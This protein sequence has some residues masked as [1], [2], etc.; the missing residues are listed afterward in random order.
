M[1]K[2]QYIS[3]SLL[4]ENDDVFDFLTE[5]YGSRQFKK[6]YKFRQK[7]RE[8]IA[9]LNI[10]NHKKIN[11]ISSTDE[12]LIIAQSDNFLAIAK[13]FNYHSHPLSYCESDNAISFLREKGHK[14]FYQ[15]NQ[16]SYDRGLLFRLDYVTSGLILFTNN[17]EILKMIRENYHQYVL[18]KGYLA[19]VKGKFITEIND[20]AFMKVSGKKGRVIQVSNEEIDSSWNKVIT[21]ISPL[22]YSQKDDL[23]LVLVNIFTGHRHQ[24]RAHLN[25][26]GF[27]IYGDDLY[28]DV[29]R[30]RVFLHSFKYKIKNP[31]SKKIETFFCD[32]CDLF[33]QFFNLDVI[34][35]KIN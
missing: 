29:K 35:N 24:I 27:P 5:I 7:S 1:S 16:N 33:Y 32:R 20:T 23:S 13:P 12:D 26:L 9:D 30:E 15:I 2:E 19:I 6:K 25:F 17:E 14:A 18:E 21:K 3:F 11:P 28:G 31:L 22:E 34:F 8:I 4:N 10:L